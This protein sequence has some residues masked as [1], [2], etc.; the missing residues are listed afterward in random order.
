MRL[1]NCRTRFSRCNDTDPCWRCF[2]AEKLE[3]L[4]SKINQTISTKHLETRIKQLEEKIIEQNSLILD[5]LY[6]QNDQYMQQPF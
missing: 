6:K 4:E 5:I 3:Y 2:S 1:A